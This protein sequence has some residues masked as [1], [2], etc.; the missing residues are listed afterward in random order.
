MARQVQQRM[1]STNTLRPKGVLCGFCTAGGNMHDVTWKKLCQ[2][3]MTEQDPERLF[4]LADA[5]NKVLEHPRLN[6]DEP[7]E[8]SVNVSVC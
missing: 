1:L 2:E 8:S 5:L 4:A 6:L 3:I 7:V